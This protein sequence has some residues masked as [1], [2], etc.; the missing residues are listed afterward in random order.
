MTVD[1]LKL[2]AALALLLTPAAF[3]HGSRGRYR[4]LSREWD[5]YWG[6]TLLYW[7]HAFDLG[8]A[9]VGAWLLSTAISRTPEAKGVLALA[10]VAIRGAVLCLATLLQTVVCRERDAM[11]APFAFVTGFSLCLIPIQAALPALILAILVSFGTLMRT[12][13]FPVLAISSSGLA[14]LFQGGKIP[15][16]L[17]GVDAA[18]LLPWVLPVLFSSH[19]VCAYRARRK[20]TAPPPER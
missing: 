15:T 17:A 1:W 7:P 6:R 3:F 20:T 8:R 4:E 13:F 18:L 12:L 5:G 9:F 10:P 16:D 14:A 19:L 11:N 2:F